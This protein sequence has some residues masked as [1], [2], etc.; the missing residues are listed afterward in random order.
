MGLL[1]IFKK[2][3]SDKNSDSGVLFYHEDDYCQVELSPNENL[4]LFKKEFGQINE[5]ADRSFDGYGYTDIYV[6]RDNRLKLEER[7][8]NPDAL[9]NVIKNIGVE[10]ATTVKTGYGSTHRE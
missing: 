3:K 4:F 9:E 7:K 2:D 10:K 5:L 8:I 6:R 1:D